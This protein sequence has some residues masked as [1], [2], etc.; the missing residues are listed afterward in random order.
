MFLEN[1]WSFP[2]EISGKAVCHEILE[3][4]GFFRFAAVPLLLLL[5]SQVDKK[6]SVTRIFAMKSEIS[7]PSSAWNL[8]FCP[9]HCQTIN[10]GSWP[11]GIYYSM[12]SWV[13]GHQFTVK[14]NYSCWSRTL[15]FQ[16]CGSWKGELTLIEHGD[17]GLVNRDET[18]LHWDLVKVVRICAQR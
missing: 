16:V 4:A 17:G 14:S 13:L 5:F 9:P 7:T 12:K 6:Q 2:V 10:C 3:N 11:V 18:E 8:S 15:L 1:E